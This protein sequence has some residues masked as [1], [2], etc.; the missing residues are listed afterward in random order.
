MLEQQAQSLQIQDADGFDRFKNGFIVDNFTGHGIGDVGNL[1]YKA[2]MDMAEGNLRP[3]FKEDAVQLIERDNDGTALVAADRAAANYQK[4]GDLITLPYT[5]ETLV[6][7]PFASKFVNVNPFNVFTWVGTIELTPPGD[8][9]KETERVPDLLVNQQGQF[10][11]MVANLG[12]PNLSRIEIGTVWNEWQD[13]WTGRPRELSTRNIGG[14][15]REQTFRFGVPRRVLQR[16]EITTGRQV[17]QT[18]TGVRSVFVP[19]T[20]RRSLGDRVLSV[21]FIPFIRSRTITFE[22]TRFKPNTRVYPFF[23]NENVSAYVTPTG[24]SLG[25]NLV[26]DANGALSGTFAIPDPTVDSN[27]RWQTGTR[28]FRLTSSSVNDLNSDIETA[29]EADY[30]ARGQLETVRETIVS[31]REPRLVRENTRENR[32]ITRTST[33]ETNRQVGWWDPL[34]QTFLID[35]VG[36]VFLSSV[37]LYFQS[38]DDNVPITVQIREV[39]NGYPTTNILPFSE[40]SINPSQVNIS[41]DSTVATTFTF[42]SPIY[43]QENV[44]YALV[45]LANSKDYNAWVARMGETQVNSD[46]TI[47]EQPYAGVLFKSQNGTTWT[48]DQNEDIKFKLKRCEFENVTGVVTLTNDDLPVRTLVANPIR[49]TNGSSTITI[50]HPNH[51]MHGTDNNVT[52]AGVASGTYNGL[53]ASEINGTYTSISNITLDSYDVTSSGTAT[54]S[55]DVGGSSVTA[56]QNRVYDILNLNIQTMTVPE[57]QIDYKLRPTTAKSIHGSESEFSLTSAT[58]EL[59]VIGN[60]NI[61]FTAPQM[62]ASTINETNE[63]SGSK[64]LF[65]NLEFRTTNTKL[66]PVLDVQRMS[67]ITVQNRLNN[68]TSGNTPN[69]VDDEQPTG[70]S[71]AAIYC[72]RPINLENDSTS[73]EVRLTQNVRS[74]SSVRVYYR[75][76]S[77]EEVRNIDELN[78]IPFN[79]DGSEDITVTPAEDET[80]FKEYKYSASGI[81]DFTAFQIKIVMKGTNSAYPPVIQD[82]RGIALA[83]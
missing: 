32:Q 78:W 55:G 21:A 12:N 59:S 51:G 80:E 66:S 44:E 60:D 72:T 37:D 30:T 67:A 64:S 4:T 49:T 62:V 48:A 76:S 24:G 81:H 75:V 40:V 10:D 15:V 17:N 58:N 82:L 25:G 22:G 47:S 52:I 13:M 7:Q 41:D 68:P 57:T 42:K 11:T 18:R 26:S 31:T 83:I 20:V 50:S 29:G 23:D 16:Q 69:F 74:S 70:S 65:L 77:S 71:T 14:R 8:E 9:W 79:G 56:T 39:Q 45:V 35:D 3:T 19:Q 61:Y 53:D 27:P 63:M 5:E 33:R 36:G 34:A 1:D 43:I 6:D 38:K 2:A 46:R 54:A 73:L 28:V